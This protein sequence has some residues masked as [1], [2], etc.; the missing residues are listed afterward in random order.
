MANNISVAIKEAPGAAKGSALVL[1]ANTLVIRDRASHEAAREFLK[2][3]K[4]LKREIEAHY[5]AIK[6]PLNEARAVVLD[7]EKK[8]LAPVDQAIAIAERIDTAYVQEQRRIEEAELRRREEEE[9]AKEQARRAVEAAEAERVALEL[10]G[11]SEE[12][13]ARE[14]SF[15]RCYLNSDKSVKALISCAKSAG[16]RD[17]ETMAARLVKS[18]KIQKAIAGMQAAARVREQAEAAQQAPIHVDV[19]PVESQIGKVAGTSV[20]T[21][22]SCGKVNLVQLCRDA[23]KAYDAGD[24]SKMLALQADTVFLNDQARQLKELFPA[25][26]PACELAKREGVTG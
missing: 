5:A 9:R 17:P 3:A 21:Y 4:L 8:H 18:A 20:R 2:G 19:A 10:E 15:C 25:V 16:Y 7:L 1:Q 23:L 12:L 14:L 11:A 22:Y 26:W 6:K 13:S 24:P